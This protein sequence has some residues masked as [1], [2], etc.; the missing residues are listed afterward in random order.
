M[1]LCIVL[2]SL[3]IFVFYKA[4]M[5]VMMFFMREELQNFEIIRLQ[6]YSADLKKWSL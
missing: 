4:F 6:L 3:K 2:Y 1:I 5:V